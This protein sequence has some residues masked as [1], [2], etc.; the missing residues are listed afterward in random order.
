MT[1][2]RNIYGERFGMQYL[3]C[4]FHFPT[5]TLYLEAVVVMCEVLCC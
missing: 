3:V 1:V 4:E 2:F 5:D